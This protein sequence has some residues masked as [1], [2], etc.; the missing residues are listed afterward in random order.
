MYSSGHHP[1]HHPRDGLRRVPI[2]VPGS[3]Y[4]FPASYVLLLLL[5][6]TSAPPSSVAG[7]ECVGGATHCDPV[8]L[9]L[10]SPQVCDDP[11]ANPRYF[12]RK[13]DRTTDERFDWCQLARTPAYADQICCPLTDK[14]GHACAMSTFTCFRD[15]ELVPGRSDNQTWAD[16]KLALNMKGPRTEAEPVYVEM[17][18]WQ[19]TQLVHS[20]ATLLLKEMMGYEVVPVYPP[21]TGY[22]ATFYPRLALGSTT[23]NFELWDGS[24]GGDIARY[25]LGDDPLVEHGPAGTDGSVHLFM[26]NYAKDTI[27]AQLLDVNDRVTFKTLLSSAEVRDKFDKDDG[28]DTNSVCGKLLKDSLPPGAADCAEAF[29]AN[30]TQPLDFV[31]PT[32][33]NTGG[34]QCSPW[35]ANDAAIT[36]NG[37]K[38]PACCTA[39]KYYTRRCEALMQQGSDAFSPTAPDCIEAIMVTPQTLQGLFESSIEQLNLPIVFSYYGN[40]DKLRAEIKARMARKQVFLFYWFSPDPLI[41]HGS[42]AGEA[43]MDRLVLPEQTATCLAD[44]TGN[45]RTGGPAIRCDQDATPIGKAINKA[46]VKKGGQDGA[47]LRAFWKMWRFTSSDYGSI[48]A[49]EEAGYNKLTPGNRSMYQ[50]V[51]QWAK[52]NHE[53][54]EGWIV[55]PDSGQPVTLSVNPAVVPSDGGVQITIFGRF[56]TGRS[57]SVLIGGVPCPGVEVLDDTRAV[58]TPG[59]GVQGFLPVTINRDGEFSR[60]TSATPQFSYRQPS[61]F[62]VN[63]TWAIPGSIVQ[64]TGTGFR[65]ESPVLCRLGI[66]ARPRVGT[67]VSST[68]IE[69]PIAGAGDGF[70]LKP[71][72]GSKLS[73]DFIPPSFELYTSQD[74]GDRWT[75]PAKVA[76]S[77]ITWAAGRSKAPTTEQRPE[78]IRVGV[79]IDSPSSFCYRGMHKQIEAINADPILLAGTKLVA[80]DGFY[81]KHLNKT[82]LAVDAAMHQLASGVVATVGPGLS[83]VA[84]PVSFEVATPHRL[85]LVGCWTSANSLSSTKTH[86]FFVRNAASND[87]LA[88][89]IVAVIEHFQWHHVAILTSDTAY[90][91]DIGKAVKA[92]FARE[93]D[94]LPQ[95][96]F[97]G[98]FVHAQGQVDAIRSLVRRAFDHL[99]PRAT[100]VFFLSAENV[101]DCAYLIRGVAELAYERSGAT[102]GNVE[103]ALAGYALVLDELCTRAGVFENLRDHFGTALVTPGRGALMVIATDKLPTRPG[104]SIGEQFSSDICADGMLVVAHALERGLASGD[105]LLSNTDRSSSPGRRIREKV[106]ALIRSIEIASG[107]K[108]GAGRIRF[109]VASNDR[110]VSTV[111]FG[112]MNLVQRNSSSVLLQPQ[113]IGAVEDNRVQLLLNK[114]SSSTTHSQRHKHG[115]PSLDTSGTSIQWPGN[116]G[117]STPL[118]HDPEDSPRRVRLILID[119]RPD[120]AEWGR[121][122]VA[123][124][125]EDPHLMPGVALEANVSIFALAT[126]PGSVSPRASAVLRD[127]V[128]VSRAANI[129]VAVAVIRGSSENRLQHAYAH[130]EEMLLVSPRAQAHDLQETAKFPNFLSSSSST[131][132]SI[133]QGVTQLLLRLNFKRITILRSNSTSWGKSFGD[134]MEGEAR[135]AGIVSQVIECDSSTKLKSVDWSVV[136]SFSPVLVVTAYSDRMSWCLRSVAASGVTVFQLVVPYMTDALSSPRFGFHDRDARLHRLVNGT[137]GVSPPT[138]LVNAGSRRTADFLERWGPK[139]S[140]IS[141]GAIEIYDT[142]RAIGEGITSCLKTGRW[143][144]RGPGGRGMKLT[145]AELKGCLQNMP[146]SEGLQG[147]MVFDPFSNGASNNRGFDVDNYVVRTDSSAE[148]GVSKTVTNVGVVDGARIRFAVCP[149]TNVTGENFDGNVQLGGSSCSEAMTA[150]VLVAAHPM[151]ESAILVK[152]TRPKLH[153]LTQ[154]SALVGFA[155]TLSGDLE[156]AST[157]VRQHVKKDQQQ[158]VI[159][160]SGASTR[161]GVLY[162]VQVRALYAGQRDDAAVSTDSFAVCVAHR[163]GSNTCECSDAQFNSLGQPGVAP[164]NWRCLP[165]PFDPATLGGVTCN[166]RVWDQVQS[167]PGYFLALTRHRGAGHRVGG[168]LRVVQCLAGP[169]G[170]PG[171]LTSGR[172]KKYLKSMGSGWINTSHSFQCA[173]GYDGFGC[174]AC[175]DGFTLDEK[176]YSCNFCPEAEVATTSAIMFGVTLGAVLLVVALIAARQAIHRR[177]PLRSRLR[178]FLVRSYRRGGVKEIHELFTGIDGDGSGSLSASEFIIF[179]SH[180][181]DMKK[182]IN[183]GIAST[184]MTTAD[185][186]R[187]VS[188]NSSEQHDNKVHIFTHK[189]CDVL[190]AE[191]DQDADGEIG[192]IISLDSIT[193]CFEAL[194]SSK[195]LALISI[196]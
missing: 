193:S 112:L 160:V 171:H 77:D 69:C 78:T 135:T 144:A 195:S 65:Q 19:S 55:N 48:F 7:T 27:S 170:C 125:N 124:I 56:F 190:F 36:A 9:S 121:R 117:P 42:K 151:N 169:K 24:K 177:S 17:G 29:A 161:R 93:K 68:Q 145:A 98:Q 162:Q 33:C 163:G 89:S 143:Y 32:Q 49:T 85:P 88:S 37:G 167:Q 129:P 26:P 100:R 2:A 40:Y 156:G 157:V 172:A 113:L 116:F 128:R 51:C 173:N 138:G 152:W 102:D 23:L 148:D 126:H 94:G 122:A 83:S 181:S 96:A 52:A 132:S 155:V 13:N 174:T 137:L 180:L 187:T 97:L 118:D 188:L 73:L 185:F 147:D 45:P 115:T 86:P 158:I 136:S 38:C 175:I 109:D 62:Y 194:A 141:Q 110:A 63:A 28:T 95:T 72:E 108:T 25:A 76:Y 81:G 30:T 21:P 111:R 101:A 176:N 18:G 99:K 58:C 154:E 20:V 90:T 70:S 149:T 14:L 192:M 46:Y 54:W 80:V 50:S 39:G 47:D 131:V 191:I 91:G 134:V 1:H 6:F 142:I 123:E 127:Y 164:K 4:P 3:V 120:V 10:T 74:G 166:G 196:L 140:A 189:E 11:R 79:L 139:A 31:C 168:G 84:V 182:E 184:S 114:T 105:L 82:A 34:G 87:M 178:R 61:I 60:I 153:P 15:E 43:T 146:A 159:A 12:G 179:L 92:R 103:R 53:R 107:I 119:S 22:S 133:V 59:P 5:L 67:V 130:A 8:C 106:L 16:F 150:P 66:T 44:F 186:R 64:I 165:C 35:P 75:S 41:F 71:V 183:L 57:V 104:I